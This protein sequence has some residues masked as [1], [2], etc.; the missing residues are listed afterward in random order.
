MTGE[1]SVNQSF[2]PAC[3]Y[4]NQVRVWI[5]DSGVAD[6]EN[7]ISILVRDSR[8]NEVLTSQ[9]FDQNSLPTSGWLNLDLPLIPESMSQTYQII[10]SATNSSEPDGVS[11][12]YFDRDEYP[13]GDLI[14]NAENV[15]ND[16]LFQYG[17]SVGIHQIIH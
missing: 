14:L 8:T 15:E 2:T 17:C 1:T 5:S 10:L 9:N 7:G 3:N 11:L 4:L 16:L 13:D 12:A 6:T